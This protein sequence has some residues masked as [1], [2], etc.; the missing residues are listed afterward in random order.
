VARVAAVRASVIPDDVY[1]CQDKIALLLTWRPHGRRLRLPAHL[2]ALSVRY[3]LSCRP[4]SL[5]WTRVSQEFSSG[6]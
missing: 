4:L 3:P 5:S 1:R 2:R 6:C